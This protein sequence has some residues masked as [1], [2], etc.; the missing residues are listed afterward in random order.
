[1]G[2]K[3]KVMHGVSAV[4]VFE[5]FT[6]YF[7]Q[8]ISMTTSLRAAQRFSKGVGIILELM[9]V[10][11]LRNVLRLE[12][13]VHDSRYHR[14]RGHRHHK[15]LVVLNKFQRT[16]VNREGEVKWESDSK[17]NTKRID[18]VAA[19]IKAQLD[20]EGKEDDDEGKEDDNEENAEKDFARIC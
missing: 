4:M 9:P 16:V 15:E 13:A 14:D 18:D 20:D 11:W 10:S 19:L 1:M 12:C 5:H 3:A 8:S 17:H 7:N 2:P 6:M